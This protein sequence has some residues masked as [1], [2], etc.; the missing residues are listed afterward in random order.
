MIS[1][2]V[3]NDR[4]N[5]KRTLPVVHA[6]NTHRSPSNRL[7]DG[8]S[9][10]DAQFL[11]LLYQERHDSDNVSNIIAPFRKA[12]CNRVGNGATDIGKNV[13]PPT[14][15]RAPVRTAAIDELE[16]E[17]HFRSTALH[18]S[19]ATKKVLMKSSDEHKRTPSQIRNHFQQV[20]ML[21]AEIKRRRATTTRRRRISAPSVATTEEE[22]AVIRLDASASPTCRQ[23]SKSGTQN[24][25]TVP[26]DS[27]NTETP[28]SAD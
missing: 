11:D 7:S 16:K 13:R 1:T 26:C 10:L 4:Y 14:L 20:A 6:T 21:E 23:A 17:F 2:K 3:G 22:P 18:Q 9:D 8:E 24:D 12:L 15:L 5:T 28:A 27:P 25:N 19:E